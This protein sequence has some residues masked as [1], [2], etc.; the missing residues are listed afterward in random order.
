[1]AKLITGAQL[2]QQWGV[3]AAHALYI[4]DGHWYHQLKRFPGAL[5]D[6]DGYLLFQT[7]DEFRKCPYL[8]IGKD[9]SVPKPGISAIP[10]YVLVVGSPSRPAAYPPEEVAADVSFAEGNVVRIRVNRY[11]RDARAR[12]KCIQHYGPRCVVC[13][14]EF[15]KMYG[16]SLSGFIHIH[17][18]TPLASIGK[19]YR[20][21]PV[22]DLRPICANCHA[23]VHRREPP[24]TVEEVQTMLQQAAAADA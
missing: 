1:M 13:G 12:A 10:G 16:Q 11:E 19:T 20:V 17:H 3:G 8:S 6:R 2:N 7:E 14:F 22:R 4:H 21:N 24:L 15:G 18:L 23:V 5:F 9:V